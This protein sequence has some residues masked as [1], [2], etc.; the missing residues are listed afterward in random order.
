LRAE[1]ENIYVS[2]QYRCNGIGKDLLGS[3]KTWALT[4]GAKH[5][6]GSVFARNSQATQFYQLEEFALYDITLELSI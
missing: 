6:S 3:F 5:L 2:D 4:I 1:I